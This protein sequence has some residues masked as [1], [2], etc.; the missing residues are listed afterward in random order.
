MKGVHK[1]GLFGSTDLPRD[2]SHRQRLRETNGIIDS[3]D[4]FRP[5]LVDL[6][7]EGFYRHLQSLRVLLQFVIRR[8]ECFGR[9]WQRNDEFTRISGRN[10]KGWGRGGVTQHSQGIT[11]ILRSFTAE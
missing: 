11:A 10:K 1:N 9:W 5:K 2:P 3:P 6:L 4:G 7:G 8:A